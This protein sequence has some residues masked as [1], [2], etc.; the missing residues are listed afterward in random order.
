MSGGSVTNETTVVI[1]GNFQVTQTEIFQDYTKPV[2][3][4]KVNFPVGLTLPRLSWQIICKLMN[5]A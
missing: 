4:F 5:S 1:R 2:F 3:I